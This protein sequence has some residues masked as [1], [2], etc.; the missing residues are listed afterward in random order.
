M[1]NEDELNKLAIQAQLANQTGQTLQSQ[2]DV[3]QGTIAEINSTLETLRNLKRAKNNTLLP[4]GSGTYVTCQ[5]IENE[6]VLIAVGAGVIVTKKGEEAIAM[7]ENR[8]KT[9]A[10]AYDRAQK[11]LIDVNKRL[12]DLN[13]KA[14]ALTA[15]DS[16][17]RPA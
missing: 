17:V 11:D 14:M 5:K 4:I 13:Q 3:L 15:Q 1:A 16:N 7:L 10:D 8:L 12:Q 9:V 2:I 6:E